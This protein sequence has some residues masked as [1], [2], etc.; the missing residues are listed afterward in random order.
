MSSNRPPRLRRILIPALGFFLFQTAPPASAQVGDVTGQVQ[1][2]YNH[3]RYGGVVLRLVEEGG[4]GLFDAVSAPDGTFTLNGVP[5]GAYTLT[6]DRINFAPVDS[7]VVVTANET[8]EVILELTPPW[9]ADLPSVQPGTLLDSIRAEVSRPGFLDLPPGDHEDLSLLPIWYRKWVRSSIP[10]LLEQGPQQYPIEDMEVLRWALDHQDFET[11]DSAAFA[12]S[13]PTADGKNVNLTNQE[14]VDRETSVAIDPNAPRYVIAASN[15]V[16][17]GPW[18]LATFRSSD[19]GCSW[20]SLSLPKRDGAVLSYDPSV[21]WHPDGAAW[22]SSIVR[23]PG[24]TLPSSSEVQLYRS[25]TRGASW[26]YV[27]TVSQGEGNDKEMIA[28]DPDPVGTGFGGRIFVAWTQAGASTGIRFRWSDNNGT[29]W[30]PIVALTSVEGAAPHVAVGRGGHVYVAWREASGGIKVATSTNGGVSFPTLA[31]V[32]GVNWPDVRFYIPA[33]CDAQILGYPVLAV[34]R[35]PSSPRVHLAWVDLDSPGV[36]TGCSGETGH[37]DVYYSTSGADGNSWSPPIP[38]PN[39]SPPGDQ[40]NPWMDVDPKDPTGRVHLTYYSTEVTAFAQ[41]DAVRLQYISR[42]PTDPTGAWTSPVAVATQP[43]DDTSD[44]HPGQYGHY[45]GLAAFGD[46]V[47]PTWTDGRPG[48]PQER[49]QIFSA[50]VRGGALMNLSCSPSEVAFIPSSRVWFKKDTSTDVKV[51]VSRGG[52]PLADEWVSLAIT[53]GDAVSAEEPVVLTDAAGQATVRVHGE[54]RGPAT[55]GAEAAGAVGSLKFRVRGVWA[56][57]VWAIVILLGIL[58]AA[59]LIWLVWRYTKPWSPGK[60][61]LAI[62]LGVIFVALFTF[63]AWY[64]FG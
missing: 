64:F 49:H 21:A 2:S 50:T 20:N 38:I 52:L 57:W 4:P 53:K 19:G 42:A 15:S 63:V 5:A 59:L 55:L 43:S 9:V 18:A 30:S 37:L 44:P 36:A 14:V 26:D 32:S 28:I 6:A 61:L 60:W 25:T 16:T 46:N 54:R 35:D 3:E 39:T 22:A 58:I 48:L 33:S 11:H 7:A 51:Q 8:V 34:D 29:S 24:G 27:A 40:F 13:G 12:V 1:S 47:I 45:S 17:S 62:L 41:R 56:W 10:G 31:S 23:F